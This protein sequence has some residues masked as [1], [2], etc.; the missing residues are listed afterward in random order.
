[1]PRKT[2]W[3]APLGCP[4]LP[5]AGPGWVYVGEAGLDIFIFNVVQRGSSC[6]EQLKI[7]SL[8]SIYTLQGTTWVMLHD[9]QAAAG[10]LQTLL[11]S[12]CPVKDACCTSSPSVCGGV[13]M[14]AGMHMQLCA[15]FP[16][17]VAR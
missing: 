1:M 12:G 7:T 6:A 5:S 9:S 4:G 11:L 13:R 10:D 2:S 8:R 14:C 15:Q 3:G 16:C 17:L